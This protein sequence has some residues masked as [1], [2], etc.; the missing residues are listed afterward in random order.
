MAPIIPFLAL[1][2]L[3]Q[4]S[5]LHSIH[6]DGNRHDHDCPRFPC[7]K[8]GD[9]AFPY[10]QRDRP[11]C[12]MFVVKGCNSST[13]Q[14]VQVQLEQGGRWYEVDEISQGDTLTIYDEILAKR[15]CQSLNKLS[16]PNL[17]YVSFEIAP[18]ITLCKCK[19]A[20]N[21]SLPK[22][23]EFRHTSCDNY[24]IY[25]RRPKPPRSGGDTNEDD[26]LRSLCHCPTIQLPLTNPPPDN[27]SLFDLLTPNVS[28][29]V[30]VSEPCWS[31]HWRGGACLA[32]NQSFHCSIE[33]HHKNT[34]TLTKKTGTNK[35]G[36]KLGIG[37]GSSV[38]LMIL[39]L[40][41]FV[42]RRRRRNKQKHVSSSDFSSKSDLENNTTLCFGVPI[43][44]YNEL[45]E[46]TNNF[47]D[48]KVLGD[49]G[50]GTVYY[51][52]LQDGREVA[53][54]RLYQHNFRRLQQFIN[55]VEILTR[56]RHK[57]LVSL[58]GCTSRRSR[59]LLLVYEFIPNGTVADHLH[60]DLARS[61]SLTWSVRM[62]IAIETAAALAYLHASD[63]IHRDVK[64]NNILLDDNFSVKVADFGLS[65]LF[66]NDVTHVST[67]PQGTPGYVDP[68]YHQCYQ[69]TEKSD[70]YSFGVVLI[71][72][73]SSMP[74]VD[75]SRHRHEINLATLAINKIQKSAFDELI[76]TNLGYRS[77]EQV[78][79]MTNSVAELAFRCLQQEKELR[80]S[81]QEVLEEL[82][83]IQSEAY[84]FESVQQEEHTDCEAL[85]SMRPPPSPLTGDEIVLLKD[86]RL[87]ASP[88]SVTDRWISQRTT[89]NASE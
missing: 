50:F 64:T 76:D 34:T 16:L 10:T 82:Q 58:Y 56:L 25:Y 81:M 11:D 74:A 4:F 72:L 89:P 20:L 68:E 6:D 30:H 14:S 66:P 39:L 61:G 38:V 52:K 40:T 1:I 33:R 75:I 77:C 48:R 47:D 35:M 7:G 86:I 43:F 45:V 8:L 73:I 2:V 60:G 29:K 54:K 53:I 88:I 9:L 31:C 85:P 32:I 26:R 41:I 5:V 19:T 59:E 46:A 70:V 65:R 12:G 79:G 23:A 78:T 49:G 27:G 55:E 57:N 44:S 62:S 87:P 24:T 80:P 13:N 84:K 21:L 67:A 71:E 36:L 15:D 18:N 37:I 63:I 17:P 83:R 22:E 51:G 69:L 3:T 42:F 28:V